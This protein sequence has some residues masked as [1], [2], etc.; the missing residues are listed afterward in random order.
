MYTESDKRILYIIGPMLVLTCVSIVWAFIYL[1]FVKED[2]APTTVA[3]TVTTIE[4]IGAPAPK[5]SNILTEDEFE[6][7]AK[8]SEA[9][10]YTTYEEYYADASTQISIVERNN[11]GD[12]NKELYDITSQN[13]NVYYGNNRISPLFPMAVANVET[14]SRADHNLTWSALYPSKYA[15]VDKMDT[16]NVCDVANNPDIL[17]PLS[18]EVS[19][20]DRGALQMS[21]TYGTSNKSINETMSGTEADKLKQNGYPSGA[22]RWAS[23]A[24]TSPGDRFYLPD[25][26]KRM[27]AAMQGQVDNMFKNNYTPATDMQLIAMCAMGHHS[28][29][30]WYHKDKNK[31]VG[32]WKSG[33]LAYEYATKIGNADFVNYLDDAVKED[34]IYFLSST[35]ATNI[36]KEYFGDCD[37]SKYCT[38][39]IV[40]T[41]PIK[42]MYNYLKLKQL[43]NGE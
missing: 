11:V 16:F 39:D 42:V 22:S 29:G 14:P 41:Y 35:Q 34:N 30:V 4:E 24:S 20:R 18:A 32:K 9:F 10:S 28:S 38:R 7:Y 26:C 13:F 3:I 40:C 19:T 1:I 15:P 5:G 37:F 36:Y 6:I 27:Q 8:T 43:Y 23:G 21:P 12:A 25:V 2:T 31:T 17:A 33:Q